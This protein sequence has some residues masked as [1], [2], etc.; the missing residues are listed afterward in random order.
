M[1]HLGST[2]PRATAG[3]SDHLI[4][5]D[6]RDKEEMW[7]ASMFWFGINEKRVRMIGEGH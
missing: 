2:L 7:M 6:E 1:Q 3:F 4:I 5:R